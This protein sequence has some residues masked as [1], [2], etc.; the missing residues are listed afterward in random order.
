MLKWSHY[1]HAILRSFVRNFDE[2]PDLATDQAILQHYGWRSFFLDVTSAP[3]VAA[4][5][6]S[7]TCET[8]RSINMAEDCF[9][10]AA[11]LIHEAARYSEADA[12]GVLYVLSKKAL[13]AHNIQAVD[14]QEI[15]TAQG[16]PRYL[17]QSAWMVGPLDEAVPSDCI[18]AK[19]LAPASALNEYAAEAGLKTQLDLFPAPANDPVLKALLSVPW[20]HRPLEDDNDPF[21]LLFYARGLSIPEYGWEPEKRHP[22]NIAF[23]RSYW[24]ANE[25]GPHEPF[26]N[27]TYLLTPEFSF[28]GTDETG[29]PCPS[30][31]KFL[32]RHKSIIIEMDGLLRHPQL[33]GCEYGKGVHLALLSGDLVRIGE[34]WVEQRG[35][36]PL[37]YG[38]TQGRTY[39]I[40]GNKI[41]QPEP[42][43]D[44]CP[45]G[46]DAVH[47]H[48]LI[49][50]LHID[51]HLKERRFSKTGP[52]VYAHKEI[53]ATASLA[54]LKHGD[55]VKY[56]YFANQN[57]V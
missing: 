4:W 22:D 1:S 43:P 51:G 10:D 45:C 54:H 44:D 28:Y 11:M 47:Q 29:R 15:I 53:D 50:V 46:N 20:V 14:L 8:K 19:I 5:F 49:I 2:Q 52:R 3:A 6:A 41:L 55:E 48:H 26:S 13:R 16:Q 27:A 12:T 31:V 42:R 25:F 23:Y 56:P 37:S 36:R 39:R 7:H 21:Q 33:G 24:I 9:E 57:V 32:E 35:M 34:I 40:D 17:V 18:V 38:T 30:L